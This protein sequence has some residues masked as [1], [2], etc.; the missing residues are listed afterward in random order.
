MLIF[1]PRQFDR[2]EIKGVFPRYFLQ[3]W[4]QLLDYRTP[5]TAQAR[6]MNGCAILQELNELAEE[7]LLQGKTTGYLMA[8]AQEANDRRFGVLVRDPVLQQLAAQEWYLLQPMLD[9]IARGNGAGKSE[10]EVLRELTRCARD[11]LCGAYR[12]GIVGEILSIVFSDDTEKTRRKLDR[13][14]LLTGSLVSW[15]VAR[16]HS[17]NVLYNRC[18]LVFQQTRRDLRDRLEDFLKI[19]GFQNLE[20]AVVFRLD[21]PPG[22]H[23]SAFLRSAPPFGTAAV[24]LRDSCPLEVDREATARALEK[25][26]DFAQV[27]PNR[28][29]VEILVQ[30]KDEFAAALEASQTL[31]RWF[32]AVRMLRGYR[33][34]LPP[35]NE[36]LVFQ[37][38]HFSRVKRIEIREH[39]RLGR[40]PTLDRSA[41][42][43]LGS[44]VGRGDF[45]SRHP[46]VFRYLEGLC[47]PELETSFDLLW[48]AL[49]LLASEGQG[50]NIID[51]V[52]TSVAKPI[53]LRAV[54]RSLTFLLAMLC[55]VDSADLE[56]LVGRELP[57]PTAHGADVLAQ[58][59]SALAQEA[60][61]EA[62]YAALEGYEAAR[63]H[64]SKAHELVSGQTRMADRLEASRFSVEW[65]LR[66]IYRF[67]NMIVHGR[68]LAKPLH[69]LYQHLCWYN[70]VLFQLIAADPNCLGQKLLPWESHRY[71]TVVADLRRSRCDLR[72][73]FL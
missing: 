6:H 50:E 34:L 35:K 27:S 22:I 11:S 40:D 70:C 21:L 37:K 67:R 17:P 15:L 58:W 4:V 31:R 57:L 46:A 25:A 41:Q 49:E 52:V 51:R 28:V 47:A 23:A 64:V 69:R 26:S 18:K 9:R 45:W 73:L 29:W 30:A 13:L 39:E 38:E 65:Q 72:Q 54:K 44:V 68:E 33:N 61:A 36:C 60:K 20:H 10:L 66:R 12:K 5:P 19:V 42:D 43:A 53:A 14:S 8:S 56:A 2:A 55:K 32:L 24:S 1:H 63:M 62:L 7:A 48:R 71:D 59:C 16:G 3:L